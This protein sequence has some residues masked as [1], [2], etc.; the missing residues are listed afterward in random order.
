MKR[1]GWWP[2]P[3]EIER[4]PEVALLAALD[5]ALDIAAAAVVAAHPN[6]LDD[7]PAYRHLDRP[8][9][10]AADAI[11]TRAR[12][13]RDALDRYRRAIALLHANVDPEREPPGGL[14]SIPF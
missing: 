8:E 10:K 12:R 2:T 7:E 11:L 13:L 4:A 9:M 1:D 3:P 5:H 14:D 6:L